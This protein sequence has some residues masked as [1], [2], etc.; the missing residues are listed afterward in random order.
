MNVWIRLSQQMLRSSILNLP[1]LLW[2]NGLW[3][4]LPIT[5]AGGMAK[6]AQMVGSRDF[7]EILKKYQNPRFGFAARNY[8][9]EFLAAV[10]IYKQAGEI[11]PDVEPVSSWAYEIIQLPKAIS[12]RD[13]LSTKS[14]E[15]V[16]LKTHNPALSA[17]AHHSKQILPKGFTLR[18]PLA[19]KEKI[20]K[21]LASVKRNKQKNNSSHFTE[22]PKPSVVVN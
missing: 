9:A 5:T 6:A 12:M 16:W 20:E 19:H 8:Y 11:F 22:L 4:L 15:A 13:L 2:E 1:K 18:V 17:S 14:L 10:D 21:K 7:G 3:R